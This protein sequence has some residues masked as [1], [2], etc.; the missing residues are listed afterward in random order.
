MGKTFSVVNLEGLTPLLITV[1]LER[2]GIEVKY[3]DLQF[4]EL[5]L[6]MDKHEETLKQRSSRKKFYSELHRL[7]D[8]KYIV[9]HQ[10]FVEFKGSTEYKRMNEK[11]QDFY[12]SRCK[13]LPD[14]WKKDLD[15]YETNR[16]IDEKLH[17]ALDGLYCSEKLHA[18]YAFILKCNLTSDWKDPS[19][20]ENAKQAHKDRKKKKY[21]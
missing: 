6:L 5:E 12:A 3:I 10:E 4:E 21:K 9:H 14:R 13:E 11:Q 19:N 16:S 17:K 15:N 7:L 20:L 18:F 2:G 1:I 8:T